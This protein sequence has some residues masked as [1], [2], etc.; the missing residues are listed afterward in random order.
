MDYGLG[1]TNYGLWTEA[2]LFQ[3]ENSYLKSCS[4]QVKEAQIK[5]Y[6]I[7]PDNNLILI[8]TPNDWL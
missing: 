3:A 4:V 1:T 6:F 7:L 5:K 2:K 8:P